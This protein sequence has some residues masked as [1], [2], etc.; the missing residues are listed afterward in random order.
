M[1]EK[2][3]DFKLSYDAK[4]DVL[5]CSLGEPQEAYSK[6]MEEG[7]FARLNPEND[8]A[9]G[10]TVIDFYKRFAEHPEKMLSFPMTT[11]GTLHFVQH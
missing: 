5:Y 3:L 2:K 8:A 6:E 4:N 10:I 7:V 9:V 11:D 1:D